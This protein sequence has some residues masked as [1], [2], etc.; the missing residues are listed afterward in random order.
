MNPNEKLKK[1]TAKAELKTPVPE[2]KTIWNFCIKLRFSAFALGRQGA[3]HKYWSRQQANEHFLLACSPPTQGA[4][5]GAVHEGRCPKHSATRVTPGKTGSGET[6]LILSVLSRQTPLLIPKHP[7]KQRVLDV[8]SRR[9]QQSLF[10]R[11]S[12]HDEQ[13]PTCDVCVQEVARLLVW[14]GECTV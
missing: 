8:G 5:P 6:K 4:G 1:S 14:T 3:L 11:V 10:Q 9:T 12:W 2:S 13:K 7:N